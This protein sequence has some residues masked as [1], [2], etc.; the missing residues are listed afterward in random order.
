MSL[1]DAKDLTMRFGGLVSV[2]DFNAAIEPGEIVGLIGPNGAGKSTVFNMICGFYKPTQGS[3]FFDGKDI[4]GMKPNNIV[5]MGLTRVFQNGRLFKKMDVIKNMLV[6]RQ[7]HF[8]AGLFDSILRT[9][10][11]QQDEKIAY[12]KS[13]NLLEKLN[14]IDYIHEEAGKLPFGIQRKLEVAR[15][16]STEPKM[17][18]L[19][20]PATGLNV[21]ETNDMIHFVTQLR[22][23]FNITI[24]L[25]EHSMRVVMSICPRIIVIDHGETIAEGRPDEI[26]GNQKVI[27]AY[28]GVDDNVEN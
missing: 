3:V 11:Y 28:L 22:D 27:E 26:R 2:A 19:D 12:E 1:L 15:A 9:P 20:E 4:T 23:E 18:L 6:G 25:I 10:V 14:L 5:D 13:I 17:L 21:E 16:M 8:K 24:L 7:R